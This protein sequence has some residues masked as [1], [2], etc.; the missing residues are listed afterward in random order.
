MK[1][2][3]Q[4]ILSGLFLVCWIA[5]SQNSEN[6]YLKENGLNPITGIKDSINKRRSETIDSIITIGITNKSFP[7]AQ[8]LVAQ[9][10]TIIFHKAFGHHT[11]DSIR[12]VVL[13]DVYDLASV[14]K[15]LG[16]LPA[17]MKLYDEGKLHLDVPFST[18]WKPWGR[19]KG[20]KDLTLRQ[21]LSHQAGL[22]PYI[23]FL[24][25]A[26]RE[27]RPKKRFIKSSSKRRFNKQAY[28]NL[29]IKNRFNRKMY[30][31]INRSEVSEDKKY[32]YSGLAFLLFPQIIENLTG[33]D[34]E[35]YLEETFYGP[36]GAKTLR[37]TPLLKKLNNSA[38][39]TEIDTLFRK[40]LVT[41][42]VHDENAAL[43]GGVSGN[44]GLF[45]NAEDVAK[46]MQM[47]LNYGTYGGKRYILENT[48]KEFTRVQ[49]PENDNY[50]GLGFD[51]PLLNNSEL[52]LSEAY[53]AP[54]V[55]PESFGHTG[56]TGTMV[57]ADP[58]NQMVFIFLSNRVYPSRDHRSLYSL[59]IRQALQQ[60]F[61]E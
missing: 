53:P 1:I 31:H 14:T 11:Y 50:R 46:M 12:P 24:S 25:E 41:G 33:E 22:E 44:A 36:I 52:E 35:T 60:V 40:A 39:P 23:V 57:W 59:R 51:K 7:G 58:K 29:F 16:P 13:S 45:G 48:L 43:L 56:F 5:Q 30:R 54:G 32:K 42:W 28:D 38:V 21:I 20:K 55:S 6:K 8:L 49:Y 27:G 37:F 19:R 10:D 9:N 26:M 4:F 2:R 47:Y 34:Y 18:Y 17:I 3:S 61:L 15:I